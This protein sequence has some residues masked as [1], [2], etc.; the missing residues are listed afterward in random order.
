L[1]A[2]FSWEDLDQ[3]EYV[4]HMRIFNN[5]VRSSSVFSERYELFCSV[6]EMKKW[7][8]DN[9]VP[10]I[11]DYPRESLRVLFDLHTQLK[12]RI[13]LN[14]N[15]QK[16]H[17]ELVNSSLM[18]WCRDSNRMAPIL[19]SH[20]REEAKKQDVEKKSGKKSPKSV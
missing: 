19:D 4:S 16:V 14:P 18:V 8:V 2:F 13:N 12:A 10:D 6:A 1:D 11:A 17:V 20:F 15:T 7:L 9:A 5:F 3:T